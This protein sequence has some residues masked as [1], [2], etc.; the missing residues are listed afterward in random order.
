M[1]AVALA[2]V[3]AVTAFVPTLEPG[4]AVPPLPLVDQ[5]GHAFSLAELRGNAVVMS[6][7]YTR[8]P[9]P[10]MCP[11]TSAKFARLQRAI[12][13]SPIR[14]LEITLDPT[15]DTPRVLNA[16]GRG[17]G[18]DPRRWTLATGAAGSI[19]ELAARLDVATQWTRPGVLV[20]TESVI[21][22]DPQ[23][24]LATTIG[25]NAWT[26]DQV[27]AIARAS[28]GAPETLPARIGAWL[29]SA[30]ALCG[31]GRGALNVLEGLAVLLALSAGIGSLLFRALQAR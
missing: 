19:A 25:G 10:T 31:G 15:F 7:I 6:F 22:L 1:N 11:L 14:L 27:L 30:I 5:T 21:V 8:C 18:A 17:F 16:Y 28:A 23:G 9:D 2:I 4:D 13:N 24:R 20:H 3:L 12:G 26:P 29:T